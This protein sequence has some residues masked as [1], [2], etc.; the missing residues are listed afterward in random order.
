M[1]REVDAALGHEGDRDGVS[2]PSHQRA[3]PRGRD[4]AATAAANLARRSPSAMG[5]RQMLP[6]HTI[7]TRSII[8]S[9]GRDARRASFFDPGDGREIIC[10]FRPS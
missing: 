3:E 4:H 7:R 10:T 6:T 5:L 8:S 2:G 9:L 1:P